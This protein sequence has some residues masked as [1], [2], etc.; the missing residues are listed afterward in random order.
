MLKKIFLFIILFSVTICAQTNYLIKQIE[1][2]YQTNQYELTLKLTKKL[3]VKKITKKSREKINEIRAVCFYSIGKKDS[4]KISFINL[5]KANENYKPNSQLVSP[6]IVAFFN[7]IKTDFERIITKKKNRITQL[8]IDS[9]KQE[10]QQSKIVKTIAYSIIFPGIGQVITKQKIKGI[11]LIAVSTTL[12]GFSIYYTLKTDQFRI[13]YLSESDRV[14]IGTKYNA[15]NKFFKTRNLFYI[16][17]GLVWLFTQIDLLIFN[18]K[19]L[20]SKNTVLLTS[21]NDYQHPQLSLTFK[22]FF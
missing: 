4:A 16:S 7:I 3:L 12:L 21:I 6:K 13:N 19:H 11:I 15:Y 14:L 2:A 10:I 18:R 20:F 9:H 17:Y 8:K 5:L 22:Y 1:N